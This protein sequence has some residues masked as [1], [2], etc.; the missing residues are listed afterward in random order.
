MLDEMWLEGVRTS[1]NRKILID[2]FH[3]LYEILC[4]KCLG[5]TSHSYY[6]LEAVWA[7]Y[8]ATRL[9]RLFNLIDSG[10]SLVVCSC[11]VGTRHSGAR[12][13]VQI[14][15]RSVVE[16]PGIID[17]LAALG[18]VLQLLQMVQTVANP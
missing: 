18:G 7:G 11:N 4:V 15:P 2:G 1:S 9:G 6:K 16:F 13:L 17:S 8:G 14:I 3:K 5:E 10:K 12:A